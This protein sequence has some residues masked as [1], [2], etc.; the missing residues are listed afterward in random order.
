M[1]RGYEDMKR[2]LGERR[3]FTAV[4]AVSDD[5]AIGAMRAVQEGGAW[6]AGGSLHRRI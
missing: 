3:D 1:E 2:L 6:G 5:V 4:F